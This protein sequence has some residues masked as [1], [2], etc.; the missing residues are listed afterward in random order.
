MGRERPYVLRIRYIKS[1]TKVKQSH[2]RPAQALRVPG[3]WHSHISRQS[4]HEGDKVVKPRHR[5]PL[6]LRIYSWDSF[7]LEAESPQ[8]HSVAGRIMSMKNPNNTIR[9]RTRGLLTC[10]AVLQPTAPPRAPHIVHGFFQNFNGK[11]PHPLLWFGSRSAGVKMTAS[12]TPNCPN[13]SEIFIICTHKCGHG[14]HNATWLASGWRC[15]DKG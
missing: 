3:G 10:S 7:L 9:N 5:P 14:P 6:P 13:L 4:V 11:M 2:Y 8:G 15:G 1:L 12:G